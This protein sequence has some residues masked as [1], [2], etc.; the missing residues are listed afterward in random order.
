MRIRV[1]DVLDLLASGLS[2]D[3]VL[4]ELPDLEAADIDVPPLCEPTVGPSHHC[5]VKI[6]LD[7]QISPI[8]ARWLENRFDVEAEAVRDVGYLEADDMEIFAAAREAHAVV[9]TKDSDFVRLVET[10]GAPSQVA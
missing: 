8:L 4:A 10:Q 9:M 6:W 3:E 5:R 2:R 1:R 7:A